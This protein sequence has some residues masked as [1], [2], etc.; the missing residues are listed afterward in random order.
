LELG[1]WELGII[2]KLG[3]GDW[4]LIH[5]TEDTPML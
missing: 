5:A 1:I 3:F 4:N 2:W